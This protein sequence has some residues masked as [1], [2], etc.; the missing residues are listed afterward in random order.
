MTAW[1]ITKDL[2]ATEEDR[3]ANPNGGS[4]YYAENLTGPRNASDADIA[5][6]KAGEGVPFRLLD[7]DGEV[8]YEGRRLETSDADEGY[9]AETEFAAL[10][11]FGKP[12]AGCTIQQEKNQDGK[13]EAIN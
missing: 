4:Y 5:R 1:I 6:L 10:D 11:G 9:G 7:D 2:I 13:W 3:Q 12:N 8:Y